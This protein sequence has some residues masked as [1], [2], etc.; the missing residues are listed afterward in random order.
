MDDNDDSDVSAINGDAIV[1]TTTIMIVTNC[2]YD[3][4]YLHHNFSYRSL[5]PPTIKNDVDRMLIM[6]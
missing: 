6:K 3:T 5:P 1:T 2:R 4:T